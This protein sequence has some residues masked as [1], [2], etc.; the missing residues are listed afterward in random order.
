VHPL[1]IELTGKRTPRD[2]LEA[3][4]SGYYGAAIGLIYGKGGLAEYTDEAARNSEV[5]ELRDRVDAEVD[6]SVAAD[7]VIMTVTMN[8]GE[9]IELNL[10]H[11]LGSVERPMTR[12]T[13]TD[14]FKDQCTKILGKDVDKASDALW[15][16]E[17]T[18][19]LSKITQYL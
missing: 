6:M 8:D 13:L 7:A 10:P 4:F 18:T 14:K 2:G 15:Q 5:I 11:C 16:I 9:V 1:V 3:K 19:D 17:E 12:E